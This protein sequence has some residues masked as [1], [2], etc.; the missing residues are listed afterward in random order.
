MAQGVTAR[1]AN[2]AGT[3]DSVQKNAPKGLAKQPPTKQQRMRTQLIATGL[4][5]FEKNGFDATTV[6]DIVEAVGISRRSFFRYFESKDDVV[7][8]WLDEQGDF[9]NPIVA[10]RPVD[11]PLLSTMRHAYLEL[12]RS[13]DQ[14]RARAT[15]WTRIVFETPSL[16]RRFR[17]ENTRWEGEVADILRRG[18]SLSRSQNFALR[19]QISVTTT[20]F[21]AAIRAW[22]ADNQRGRLRTWVEAAFA[23]LETGLS[24][25]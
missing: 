3:S 9:I 14:D 15:A 18:R 8:D 16:T 24:R 6:I 1:S 13:L 25:S 17:E 19:V 22:A 4:A 11:E 5:L 23:A 20:A 10:A 2:N 21:V 7:F 12:A